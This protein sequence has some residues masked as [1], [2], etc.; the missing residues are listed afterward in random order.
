MLNECSNS[1]FLQQ[2]FNTVQHFNRGGHHILQHCRVKKSY[3]ELQK[4]FDWGFRYRVTKLI[5]AKICKDILE[6]RGLLAHELAC[7]VKRAG[8][9][10][11]KEATSLLHNRS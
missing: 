1:K 7:E 9:E 3:V 11:G 5:R 6:L 2:T 4:P 10:A 8:K